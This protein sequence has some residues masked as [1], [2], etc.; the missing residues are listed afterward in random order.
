[1]PLIESTDELERPEDKHPRGACYWAVFWAD[2]ERGGP[3]SFYEAVDNLSS[4]D[5]AQEWL[6]KL[7][8]LDA[9]REKKEAVADRLRELLR[10]GL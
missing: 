4:A 6:G 2:E 9:D 1:M 3:E 5:N 7:N 8:E 10:A